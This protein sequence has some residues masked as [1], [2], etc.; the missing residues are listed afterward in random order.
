M[1]KIAQVSAKY[2]VH[3]SIEIEGVVDRPDV[4]GAIFGQTEG[5]LGQDL[6]LRELQ[7]SGRIGRI[8]VNIETK[9]GKT[10]GAILIPSSLDKSET[11]IIGAALE[12][13]QRIGPCNAK[14][15][16]QN[17][18]DVR[19]A[20]REHVVGR[21][22]EL[23]K[24]LMD[25]SM[26]DSQE[27]SDEVAYSVRVMEIQEYGKDR[28]PSGPDIDEA[29]EIIF[30]EGRADVITLLKHGFK[31]VIAINGTS[32][33]P[34][35]AALGKEKTVTAFVDGDRGGDLIIK[36]LLGVTDLDYVTKAPDGKEVEE[37]TK[38]EIHKALRSR[39]SVGQAKKVISQVKPQTRPVTRAPS[40]APVRRPTTTRPPPTSRYERRPPMRP[41]VTRQPRLKEDEKAK[42]KEMLE[43][44]VGTKG[45]YILDKGL[46]ILGKVPV[47][48]LA[49]TVKS[50]NSGIHA[51]IFD[52]IADKEIVESA[53]SARVKFVV[54]MQS[55]IKPG[56]S[57]SMV[58][59]SKE[60]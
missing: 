53:D 14:V 12:V 13:I 46:N 43:D 36:E 47:K 25:D 27:L 7:R 30:V 35:I 56:T 32:I 20:K 19:V 29:E 26:P 9:E 31:N 59:T 16:V 34:T 28:L 23:L 49:T 24:S 39:I 6:E 21:A 38:K 33:P 44:L 4:I 40:R 22:K 41:A 55:K 50:L 10:T 15:K 18:E 54:A 3:A 37:L 2:I 17:I 52:G 1:A 58:L 57:R 45:A 8:E 48:E 60:L 42:F 51:I 5:L 11:A